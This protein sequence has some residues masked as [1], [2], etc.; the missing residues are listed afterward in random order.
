MTTV[1]SDPPDAVRRQEL[2]RAIEAAARA[3]AQALRARRQAMLLSLR[4]AMAHEHAAS[5]ADR[6]GMVAQAQLHQ[7][8]ADRARADAS[9]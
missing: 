8:L 3:E 1:R 7:E 9:H 2:R 4:A 5:V 6:V